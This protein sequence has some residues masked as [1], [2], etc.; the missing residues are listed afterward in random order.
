VPDDN[1]PSSPATWDLLLKGGHIIDPANGLDSVADVAIAEGKIAAIGANLDAAAIKSAEV[2]GLYVTP[3]LIDIHTHHFG[4]LGATPA[5]EYAFANGITTVV[6]AGGPGYKNFHEFRTNIVDRSRS[7]VLALM[8]I[9]GGGMLGAVEQDVSEMQSEPCAERI[10]ENRDVVV[11]IK[12]AHHKYGW[13]SVDGAVRAG[14]I[15]GVFVMVDF[16]PRPERTYKQ[17]ILDHMRPGDVHTHM[18]GQHIEQLDANRKV[19]DYMWEARKRGILF[20][21]GHGGGSFWFRVAKPAMEQ[22]WRPDTISTDIHTGSFFIPRATMPLT[23]SKLMNLGMPLSEAVQ[24]STVEPARVISRPELGTL[25]VGSEADVA[26]FD[27]EKGDFGFV[28]SGLARMNGNLRLTAHMTI[29]G[30][31]VVWDLN[32]ISRPDWETQGN[33][34]RL[35]P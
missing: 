26:V 11:G 13:E 9:V 22:G 2:T 27:L 1:T 7:R 25:S 18:Y 10:M 6:D 31:Q 5:D 28:D 12:A 8:N 3:G 33:Y 15:A 24:R 16:Q 14:D 35:D 21:V 32:G 34:V 17:L 20:D 30:G 23:M 29:R 4:Y 19:P